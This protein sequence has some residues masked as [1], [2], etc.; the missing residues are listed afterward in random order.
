MRTIFFG[1]NVNQIILLIFLN[2]M[3]PSSR[4]KKKKKEKESHPIQV[5]PT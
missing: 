3:A 5:S 2:L 4:A 1:N